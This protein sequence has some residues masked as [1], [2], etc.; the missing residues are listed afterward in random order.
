MIDKYLELKIE[1][2]KQIGFKHFFDEKDKRYCEWVGLQKWNGIYKVYIGKIE[3][4]KMVAEEF[5]RDEIRE[6]QTLSE[7][8]DYIKAN[9]SVSIEK[10]NVCK[11][12]RIFNP[13][14]SA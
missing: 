13:E 12:Q 5:E 7:A 3:E 11:G 14:F 6:F 4:N 2:G 10:M 1:N 8:L 9:S